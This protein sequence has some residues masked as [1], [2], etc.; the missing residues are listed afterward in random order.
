MLNKNIFCGYKNIYKEK[1]VSN[2][3][4][5]PSD[6]KRLLDDCFLNSFLK[7]EGDLI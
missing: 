1:I 3:N 2:I 4:I 6:L 5:L 7:L